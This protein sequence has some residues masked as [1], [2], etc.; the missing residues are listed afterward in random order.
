[1]RAS[2][3]YP[4]ARFGRVESPGRAL[5]GILEDA[6]RVVRERPRVHR[7]ASAAEEAGRWSIRPACVTAPA[8]ALGGPK[9]Q[10]RGAWGRQLLIG[11]LMLLALV[12]C[13]T[14]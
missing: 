14:Y 11:M 1:M 12:G 8:P 7:G 5:A 6:C 9:M 4:S 13:F 2:S 3:R 10:R